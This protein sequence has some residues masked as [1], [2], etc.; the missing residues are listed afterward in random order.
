MKPPITQPLSI[1]LVIIFA[2]YPV[3][4]TCGGGGGG[5]VGGMFFGQ[6]V[7]QPAGLLRPLESKRAE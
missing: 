4:A 6:L 2:V 7:R 5:G 1:L 3:L